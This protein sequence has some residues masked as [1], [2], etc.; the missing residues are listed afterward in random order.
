MAW[1]PVSANQ[2]TQYEASRTISGSSLIQ[3][4]N[5]NRE[6]IGS[7]NNSDFSFNS[8]AINWQEDLPENANLELFLRFHNGSWSKWYDLHPSIDGKKGDF[9]KTAFLSSAPSNAFEYKFM[10]ET[11]GFWAEAKINNL[12]ITLFNAQPTKEIIDEPEFS[13]FEKGQIIRSTFLAFIGKEDSTLIASNKA[14]TSSSSLKVITRKQWGADESLR[15]L[16]E[17]AEPQIKEEKDDPSELEKKFAKELKIIRTVTKNSKGKKLKWPLEYAEKTRKIVI[18]HTATTDEALVASTGTTKRQNYK[19]IVNN[20]YRYHALTRGWGDVGYHYII[21]PDGRVYEG[22]YGEAVGAHAAGSNTGSLGIAVIGNYED[23]QVPKKV[24]DSIVKLSSNKT[25]KFKIKAD[26]KSSFRGEKSHNILGHRDVSATTCPGSKLYK[27]IPKIRKLVASANSQT[28]NLPFAFEDVSSTY[29]VDLNRSETKTV[30]LKLKN[31]GKT[32]WGGGSYLTLDQ[33]STNKALVDFPGKTGIKLAI[34]KES[35]VKKGKIATFIFKIRAKE[36]SGISELSITP[37]IKASNKSHRINHKIYL[38]VFVSEPIYTYKVGKSKLPPQTIKAGKNIIAWIELKNTGNVAWKRNGN[39]VSLGTDSPRDRRSI[40]AKKK[41]FARIGRLR[42]AIVKPGETGKFYFDIKA[43]NESGLYTEYFTPVVEGVTWM[44]NKKLKFTTYVYENDF[45]GLIT[46]IEGDKSIGKN[47]SNEIVVTLKNVGG[48]TWKKSGPSSLSF[49]TSLGKGASV[50]K[51]KIPPKDVKPGQ[52]IEAIITLKVNALAKNGLLKI[53]PKIGNNKLLKIGSKRFFYKVVKGKK[54]SI[55]SKSKSK[56]T[57]KVPTA[58]ADDIRVKISFNKNP[59]I[60]SSKGMYLYSG[61][62]KVTT[63][64]SNKKVDVTYKSGAYR[65]KSGGSSRSVAKPPRFVPKI[66]SILEI[67]NMN[68]RPSWNPDINDNSFRGIL[69]V[70]MDSGKL[71][72]I[73]EL[74]LESY[75]KGLA[76]N[77]NAEPIEK[78]KALIVAARTYAKYYM[79][80]DEKFPGK[81]WHIDDDPDSSQKYLGY[82]YELRGA[83]TVEAVAATTGEVITYRGKLIKTPYFSQSAGKTF[84]AQQVWGWKH[85]PYLQSVSDSYCKAGILR[86]HGVGLSGCGARGLAEAGKN[87][88]EILKYFYTGVK[89]E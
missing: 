72:T 81:A 37:F 71:V 17:D 54:S 60:S 87:Y 22:R 43:P 26:G 73:N 89:V 84:S 32:T 58:S 1:L 44:E 28:S 77:T 38:P 88:Q 80:V 13:D 25:K 16:N 35:S 61:D 40:F 50:S 4:N 56:I 83:K 31:I 23:N 79:T 53:T 41:P 86:G 34:M 69:E 47:A 82:G 55:S 33:N 7:E 36:L 12:E 5:R 21:D 11:D 2:P 27:A 29:D 30:T 49:D 52:E 24:I 70:R 3:L 57:S 68:R 51:I 48:K 9:G 15:I 19:Q 85:T 78:I 8:V 74:D 18:H 63:Y 42:D 59:S 66:N 6:F 67:A 39:T 65:V 45:E 14:K 46:S 20:I 62:K 64:S 76:E 10:L 75:L